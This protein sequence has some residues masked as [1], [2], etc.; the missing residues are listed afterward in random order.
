MEVG[1]F[2]WTSTTELAEEFSEGRISPCGSESDQVTSVK[3]DE[4]SAD[5]EDPDVSVQSVFSLFPHA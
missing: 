3:D 5:E 2:G 1:S 4:V